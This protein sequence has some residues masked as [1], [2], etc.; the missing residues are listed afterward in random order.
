MVT[1]HQAMSNRLKELCKERNLSYAELA[2]KIGVPKTKIVRMAIGAPSNPG[3]VLMMKIC[4]ALE[5]GLDEFVDTDE[6]REVR[7]QAEWR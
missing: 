2:E 7:K 3:L 5:I 4:D 6:F 1:S